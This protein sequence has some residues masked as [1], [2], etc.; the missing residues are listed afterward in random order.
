MPVTCL[1]KTLQACHFSRSSAQM[2][3]SMPRMALSAWFSH[4]AP[5]FNILLTCRRMH[6]VKQL[7]CGG[8]HTVVVSQRGELFSWGR[9]TWGQTGHGTTDDLCRPARVEALEEHA[10]VQVLPPQPSAVLQLNGVHR[11]GRQHCEP[12]CSMLDVATAL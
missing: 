9:G 12:S 3:R 11:V 1:R 8:D 5:A 2:S 10:I 6:A 4:A 7:A